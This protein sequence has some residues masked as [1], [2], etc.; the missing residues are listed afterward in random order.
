MWTGQCCQSQL[1]TTQCT[2]AVSPGIAGSTLRD[3]LTSIDT[4]PNGVITLQVLSPANV[5]W[6]VQRL[7]VGSGQTR[8]PVHGAFAFFN[9]TL[10]HCCC[11]HCHNHRN[12]CPLASTLSISAAVTAS[13][14]TCLWSLWRALPLTHTHC[15]H[16]RHSAVQVRDAQGVLRQDPRA[17]SRSRPEPCQHAPR[18]RRARTPFQG[19]LPCM[20]QPPYTQPMWWLPLYWL[21]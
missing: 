17:V 3:V 16:H 20:G 8:I 2:H 5:L 10:V 19:A 9:H 1:A 18:R 13:H 15:P 6:A 12:C 14:L 4:R 7:P 11:N 21:T